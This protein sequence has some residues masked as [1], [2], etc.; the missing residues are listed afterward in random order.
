MSDDLTHRVECGRLYY[1]TVDR[2]CNVPNHKL[3]D[4]DQ[5]KACSYKK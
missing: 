5:L 3:E 4:L 2:R 1:S